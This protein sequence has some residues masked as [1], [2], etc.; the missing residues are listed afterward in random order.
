M[1]DL[2]ETNEENYNLYYSENYDEDYDEIEMRQKNLDNRLSFNQKI[3]DINNN[4]KDR[5]SNSSEKQKQANGLKV[6][7]SLNPTSRRMSAD[8]EDDDLM[9][10][11]NKY[12]NSLQH[13]QFGKTSDEFKK[14]NDLCTTSYGEDLNSANNG[15]NLFVL[16]AT[17]RNTNAIES[18]S[19]L[20]LMKTPVKNNSTSNFLSPTCKSEYF[21]NLILTQ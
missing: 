13:F 11:S 14:A 2:E 18:R 1:D 17:K 12:F 8:T 20:D 19:N 4:S 5:F 3:T 16:L 6:S 15:A 10:N 21:V 7:D 9:I